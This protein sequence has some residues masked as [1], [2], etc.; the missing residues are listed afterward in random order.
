MLNMFDA[1]ANGGQAADGLIPG[2]FLG[3]HR[4]RKDGVDGARE[5]V[6]AE[7]KALG[8]LVPHVTKNKEG[9]E[10]VADAEPRTIQTPFGDRSGVVVEP[11]LTDQWYVD[12]EKLA[13]APMQAVRAGRI[14]IV[15][16]VR[17]ACR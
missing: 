8:M 9:E 2:R 6:V 16:I 15:Q 11:W 1:D 17:R 7:M 13:F 3:L 14:E 5:L 4:F 10:V 12:A